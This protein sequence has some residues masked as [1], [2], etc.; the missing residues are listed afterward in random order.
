MRNRTLLAFVC[1]LVSLLLPFAVAKQRG[2]DVEQC[3]GLVGREVDK[4]CSTA[5]HDY[6]TRYSAKA[7]LLGHETW[8]DGDAMHGRMMRT[9]AE[10]KAAIM[11]SD[12]CAGAFE[13]LRRYWATCTEAP[14]T[15]DNY[16]Y[17]NGLLPLPPPP[18]PEI[19][20]DCREQRFLLWT[21]NMAD[22][23]AGHSHK[24]FS[25]SCAFWE[26]QALNRTLIIDSFAG[27]NKEH[28]QTE[29]SVEAP[30]AA[31]YST[32]LFDLLSAGG[33]LYHQFVQGCGAPG[34]LQ[35]VRISLPYVLT[36]DS[37]IH[38]LLNRLLRAFDHHSNARRTLPHWFVVVGGAS[39][40]LQEAA[41]DVAI[42][43]SGS[44]HAEMVA[45]AG[46]PL[47]VRE[48]DRRVKLTPEA[49]FG[50][51]VCHQKP[52][53]REEGVDYTLPKKLW[54]VWYAKWVYR[55]VDGIMRDMKK[56]TALSTTKDAMVV[57]LHVRRGDKLTIEV[58]KERYPNL[59]YETSPEGIM[60]TIEPF[61]SHGSVL[62]IATNQQD[63][64]AF[65]APLQARYTAMT[66]Y[67]FPK[68]IP[69]HRYLPSSMAMVDYEV[70]DK[71]DRLIPTFA[72]EESKGFPQHVS[73]SKSDK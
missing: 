19:L 64:V 14:F 26:A 22:F 39:K 58:D 18:A 34:V 69:A 52:E 72:S 36:H 9:C 33:M 43:P 13:H 40:A 6:V 57:C 53:H 17:S 3:Q 67:H 20:K 63:P 32:K 70:M 28:T 24:R 45:Q 68:R 29:I 35:E 15:D 23:M 46:V 59:D 5:L 12:V 31:W 49:K 4:C 66:L 73:L 27:M 54:N 61:V 21:R 1:A 2:S 7:V 8:K 11:E 25:M 41:G 60:A 56:E 38:L 44:S 47:L 30:F 62:Y 10:R 50:F 51:Q 48:W 37:D 65:F 71:C 16:L 55:I 42:M